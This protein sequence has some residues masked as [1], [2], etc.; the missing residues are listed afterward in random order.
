[1]VLDDDRDGT[2]I[3]GGHRRKGPSQRPILGA[4]AVEVL[5]ATTMST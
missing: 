1:M 2:Q 4:L 5:D 3:V